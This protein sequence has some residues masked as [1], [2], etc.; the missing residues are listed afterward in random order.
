MIR[1]KREVKRIIILSIFIFSILLTNIQIYN[2]LEWQAGDKEKKETL[3]EQKE[4]LQLASDSYLSDYYISGSGVNQDVRLY[5]TNQS[6]SYNNQQFFNIPSMSDTDTGY[7]SSGEFNFT[8]QNNY[9]T[10]YVL[11]NTDA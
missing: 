1:R 9:T 10:E 3:L 8:F 4:E 2:S 6:T 11:E 7:L 5:V